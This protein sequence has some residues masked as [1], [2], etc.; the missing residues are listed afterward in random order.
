MA[1]KK[2]SE[3]T[4]ATSV[5]TSDELAIVQSSTTKRA[6]VGEVAVAVLGSIA[7][8]TFAEQA[9]AP[10]S[11]TD[12]AKLYALD[13]SSITHLYVR[14]SDGTTI[15]LSGTST[16]PAALGRAASAGSLGSVANADHVHDEGA[17]VSPTV[18]TSSITLSASHQ[19]L[20]VDTTSGAVNITLPSVV[21]G[22]PR[23]WLVK[24]TNTGTNKITLVR[25]ASEQIEGAVANLDL[26]GSDTSGSRPAWTLIRDDSGNW[27]VC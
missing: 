27:W 3:L 19:V 26:P 16:A 23:H 17:L 6:T 21:S 12:T 2:I 22:S 8:A 13:V 4:D 15:R 18:V 5:N 1:N 14:L 11:A 7:S 20:L 10:A 9:S 24:K 25:A